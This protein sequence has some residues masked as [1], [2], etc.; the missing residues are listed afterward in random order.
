ML[1]VHRLLAFLVIAVSIVAALLAL[2]AR[3][4]GGTAGTA[5]AHAL[6]LAQTLVVAE[7]AFG[8][9]LLADDRHAGQGV[10]YL[11]GSLAVLAVAWPFLYA[12]PEPRR[13]LLWFAGA[14]LTAA[15]LAV[16]AYMT[17]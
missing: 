7:V 15:V 9:L 5:V 10:H 6:A 2:V 14:T 4:R 13:R 3:R 12:P 17:A 8:L 1:T 16:R 11:Y